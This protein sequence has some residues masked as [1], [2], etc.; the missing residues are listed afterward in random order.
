[1]K[2]L[3]RPLRISL[4]TASLSLLALS[5]PL[6]FSQEYGEDDPWGTEQSTDEIFYSD[7]SAQQA[8]Q[9]YWNWAGD[10]PDDGWVNI[11]ELTG[12][13]DPNDPDW[14]NL[15]LAKT[16]Q[17]E[18][19]QNSENTYWL[20]EWIEYWQWNNEEEMHEEEMYGEEMYEGS[21]FEEQ[22]ISAGGGALPPLPAGANGGSEG[23]VAPFGPFI[24]GVLTLEKEY[25]RPGD[26]ATANGLPI[27]IY[28]TARLKGKVVADFKKCN[29]DGLDES[30]SNDIKCQGMVEVSFEF[31][32]TLT[33][34]EPDAFG[35]G[36][37]YS[38]SRVRG[39]AVPLNIQKQGNIIRYERSVAGVLVPMQAPGRG[40]VFSANSIM[41]FRATKIFRMNLGSLPWQ[42]GI[43]QGSLITGG[44]WIL[45]TAAGIHKSLV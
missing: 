33:G 29:S 14:I 17:W 12:Q 18:N 41:M 13:P 28:E 10:F 23:T 32:A 37:R 1:M 45:L 8:I 25:S 35:G 4:F 21:E 2:F 42:M 7:E 15:E 44:S 24:D 40:S 11:D 30:D 5:A 38:L 31:N 36:A 9:S 16:V 3:T 34:D 27:E 20:T 43:P 6:A 26:Q 39:N 19:E 22:E